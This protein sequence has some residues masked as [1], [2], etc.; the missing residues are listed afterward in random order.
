MVTGTG[1]IMAFRLLDRLLLAGSE[2]GSAPLA[3]IRMTAADRDKLLAA[4]YMRIYG[5]RVES[6]VTCC[7][8]NALFDLDFSLA[9]LQAR[10]KEG[11]GQIPVVREPDGTFR[12][13]SGCHFRL[14][15][16]EDEC[17]V[18]GMSEEF[19]E[20]TLLR[21]CVL[22]MNSPQ[23]HIQIQAAM[24]EVALVMDL[25]LAATCPECRQ[26]QNVHFDIQSFLLKALEQE[27]SRL[28]WEV[29]RLAGAY[30]WSLGEI[31]S[32]P[33]SVRRTYV[34]FVESDYPS[35]RRHSV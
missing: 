18:L 1:T 26:E 35:R 16:G 23:D 24:A 3:A 20:E 32:L 11:A 17:A 31:L 19:A 9:E 4:V 5:P 15:T 10:L 22:Q 27:K 34:A 33:R 21:R 29:H 12:L 7:R 8:C 13:A 14:P 6:S 30:G 2:N 25:D 28:F